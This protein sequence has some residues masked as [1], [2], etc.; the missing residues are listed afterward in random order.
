M[1]KFNAYKIRLDGFRKVKPIWVD[2]DKFNEIA[3]LLKT[4]TRKYLSKGTPMNTYRY[5]LIL[6][7]QTYPWKID[8]HTRK[9]SVKKIGKFYRRKSAYLVNTKLSEWESRGIYNV[10]RVKV[11]MRGRQMS[12]YSG[13]NIASDE[14]I[15]YYIIDNIIGT[16]YQNTINYAKYEKKCTVRLFVNNDNEP[17][18]AKYFIRSLYDAYQRGTEKYSTMKSLYRLVSNSIYGKIPI[19]S[20]IVSPYVFDAPSDVIFGSFDIT[21]TDHR[22]GYEY[23][24]ISNAFINGETPLYDIIIEALKENNIDIQDLEIDIRFKFREPES[25]IN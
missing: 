16:Y 5:P 19:I 23:S 8:G 22:G 18:H 20:N 14:K 11:I 25:T 9:V 6:L 10:P 7:E 15:T 12:D 3:R 17:I 1:N 4:M 13:I 2:P 24:I 21:I